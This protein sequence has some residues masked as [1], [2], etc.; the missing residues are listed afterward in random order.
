MR[1]SL[2][3]GRHVRNPLIRS[4]ETKATNPRDYIYDIL[5]LMEDADANHPDLLP[6][7]RVL[8]SETYIR[9]ARY[10]LNKEGLSYL[11]EVVGF[12]QSANSLPPWVPDWSK[13]KLR[14]SLDLDH[15]KR[16]FTAGGILPPAYRLSG[17]ELPDK[18]IVQGLIPDTVEKIETMF[19]YGTLP[20]N[21]AHINFFM[22][23]SEFMK[24][25]AMTA[26][27]LGLAY[28]HIIT[29]T[30]A[31][32]STTLPFSEFEAISQILKPFYHNDRLLTTAEEK[33]RIGTSIAKVTVDSAFLG[34]C[35]TKL[36][37]IGRI[38][39]DARVGDKICFFQGVSKPF[40]FR[41]HEQRLDEYVLIGQCYI[42][43]KM[44]GEAFM[45]EEGLGVQEI[46]LV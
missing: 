3:R 39:H 10:L 25:S 26:S 17:D 8:V 23:T 11:F 1:Q 40:I 46:T 13:T 41:A 27:G 6:D 29:L 44:R 28:P 16:E 42:Y 14:S 24:Q 35:L 18:L 34:F 37:S 15:V 31:Q 38:P 36:G 4:H 5:G 19:D 7:Y 30:L 45:G 33:S 32:S 21:E 43:G 2:K 12:P 9:A 20:W 22:N